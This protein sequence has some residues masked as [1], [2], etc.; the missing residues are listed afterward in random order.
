MKVRLHARYGV[1]QVQVTLPAIT[2]ASNAIPVQVQ[3]GTAVS[4]TL[5]IAVQ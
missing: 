2:T 1:L 4:P 5:N 3:V